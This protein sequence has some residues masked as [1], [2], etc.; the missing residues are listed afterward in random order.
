MKQLHQLLDQLDQLLHQLL[1]LLLLAVAHHGDYLPGDLV[2]DVRQAALAARG[3]AAAGPEGGGEDAGL[4]RQRGR[5]EVSYAA[6]LGDSVLHHG[7]VDAER[8]TVGD[9]ALLKNIHI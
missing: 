1:Q 9:S 5:Q 2:Q 8:E 4:G 3:H 6:R 7:A